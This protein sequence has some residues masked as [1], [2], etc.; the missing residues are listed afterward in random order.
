MDEAGGVEALDGVL[1][2]AGLDLAAGGGLG[3]GGQRATELADRPEARVV[4]DEKAEERL[5]EAVLG[6]AGAGRRVRVAM[7][8]KCPFLCRAPGGCT[9]AGADLLV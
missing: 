8:G 9:R 1:G 4:M 2:V 5:V 7:H 6:G 3:A